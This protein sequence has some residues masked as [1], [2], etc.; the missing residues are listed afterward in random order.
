MSHP[1]PANETPEELR[2][3]LD[4]LRQ[5]L[6]RAEEE[7][8]LHRAFAAARAEPRVPPTPG[9]VDERTDSPRGRPI[10]EVAAGY[11]GEPDG[12]PGTA[13]PA[14]W[15]AALA[16]EHARARRV[17]AAPDDDPTEEDVR[18]QMNEPAGRSIAELLAELGAGAGG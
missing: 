16:A 3:Q 6:A 12:G 18:R 5:R 14:R 2:R 7:L 10:P 1:Q 11:A 9:Q 4:E 8:D 15:A 17:L 13:D